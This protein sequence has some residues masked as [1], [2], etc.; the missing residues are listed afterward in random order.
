MP[1]KT[2]PDDKQPDQ[3]EQETE[4]QD[5]QEPPTEEAKEPDNSCPNCD[6]KF[7]LVEGQIAGLQEILSGTLPSDTSP[8]KV[9]WT[10]KGSRN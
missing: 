8:R 3:E 1:K 4:E 5:E 9:P 10:H 6:A 2:L 7:S